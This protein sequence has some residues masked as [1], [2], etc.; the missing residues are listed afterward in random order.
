MDPSVGKKSGSS[1]SAPDRPRLA[2][3]HPAVERQ[4][5]EA[6][7]QAV[8]AGKERPEWRCRGRNDPRRAA[9]RDRLH[10]F[11]DSLDGPVATPEQLARLVALAASAFVP[12]SAASRTF[13]VLVRFIEDLLA[14]SGSHEPASRPPSR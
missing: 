3:G 4:P 6:Y 1:G 13:R 12:R 14:R 11:L 2:N 7:L 8:A 10:E 5:S 9:A